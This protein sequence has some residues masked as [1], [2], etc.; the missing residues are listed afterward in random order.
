[1]S[2]WSD[3]ED[4]FQDWE[5]HGLKL[6]SN[7]DVQNNAKNKQMEK[8]SARNPL[9]PTDNES[10]KIKETKSDKMYDFVP[11][12]GKVRKCLIRRNNNDENNQACCSKNK[13][14]FLGRFKQS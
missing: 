1:M 8:I 4:N 14:R 2:S 6:L 13:Y 9:L 10:L 7:I 5:S 3:D 12:I 11:S